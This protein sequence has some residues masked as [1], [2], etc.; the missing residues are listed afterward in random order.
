M[1][2]IDKQ[3]P[4]KYLEPPLSIYDGAFLRKCLTAKSS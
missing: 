4:A 3:Y 2:S 1:K